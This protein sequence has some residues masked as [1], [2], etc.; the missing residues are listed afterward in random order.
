L[1]IIP[2]PM[3]VVSLIFA[4]L[5]LQACDFSQRIDTAAAVKEMK[6]RQVK[7]VLPQDIVNQVD[8][9]GQEIQQKKIMNLDSVTKA[10]AIS[11]RIGFPAEL[12][13]SFKDA[14]MVE[15][16]DALDYSLTQKQDIPPSIQKNIKGD[17][18]YYFYPSQ[19]GKITILGFAKSTVIQ[20]M[21]RP[22]IK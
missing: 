4:L 11:V 22:L 5:I 9:W 3:K 20:N 14:K 15:L 10:L 21:D 7:R 2:K 18:L 8:V 17:S 16:M 6:A 13:L 1:Y 19:T 12:K